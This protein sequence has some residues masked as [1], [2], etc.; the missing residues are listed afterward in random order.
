MRSCRVLTA[1]LLLTLAWSGHG[2]A[3]SELG[4]T[5]LIPPAEGRK[6]AKELLDNLL[7]I[8]PSEN[9]TQSLV[10]KITDRND[11]T[12]SV[13]VRFSIVV[14]PT[15]YLTVYEITGGADAGATLSIAHTQG[16]PNQYSFKPSASATLRTLTGDELMTP[17]AG[18][19]F[20]VVDLGLEFL[21]W[22]EQRVTKKQMRK[23]LFCDVLESVT[24]R[25]APKGYSKVVSWVAANR[26][27]DIVIIH[28]DAYDAKGKLLKQFDPKKVR[29]VN[30][31][32][33]LAKM[34]I[35]NRQTG[36]STTIDFELEPGR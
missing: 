26:P 5:P 23:N 25:P 6:V 12:R 3:K 21:Y 18:S 16:V 20:W 11:V 30:G 27:D 15:N 29:K 19:D 32:W 31:A 10:I 22:P 28:A 34:E 24:A 4:P 17:F 33:E 2:Q 1:L 7:N 13:S 36:S 35:R 8:R 9:S 14:T